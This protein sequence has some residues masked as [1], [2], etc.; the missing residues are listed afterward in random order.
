MC[1]DEQSTYAVHVTDDGSYTRETRTTSWDDTN[2]LVGILTALTLAV[3][4][5]VEVGDR[6]TK[7]CA[8]E[9]ECKFRDRL[10]G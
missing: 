4:M 7:F 1:V 8:N 2:V 9:V 10:F 3:G 5:V 6:F